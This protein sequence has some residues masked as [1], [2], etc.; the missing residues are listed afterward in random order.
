MLLLQAVK[1]YDCS[2][3][4]LNELLVAQTLQCVDTLSEELCERTIREMQCMC[5]VQSWEVAGT[6]VSTSIAPQS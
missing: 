1:P 4:Q 5:V 6:A 2:V 3:L